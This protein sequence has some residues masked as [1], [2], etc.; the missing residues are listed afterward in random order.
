MNYEEKILSTKNI[1]EGT[2]IN[3]DLLEVELPNGKRAKRDIVRHPGGAFVVPI[4][5]KGEIYMVR[6]FRKPMEKISLEVPAGKLD[7]GEDPAVCAEREL[8]EETGLTASKITHLLSTHTS[9]GFC[10]ELLHMYVATGLQEGDACTDEDEFLS[11]EKIHVEKLL[12]MVLEGEITDS[13]TIMGIL[14][15]ERI[16][17]GEIKI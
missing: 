14:F 16:I 11:V 8:R 12:E 15:A 10:D 17:K 6:Q 13:K 5:E 1:Y 7:P 3:L 4:N 9:P 2:V